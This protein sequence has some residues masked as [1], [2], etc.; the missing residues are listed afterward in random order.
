MEPEQ[1]SKGTEFENL[2]SVKVAPYR[3]SSSEYL[4]KNDFVLTRAGFLKLFYLPLS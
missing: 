1:V 3:I 2:E 4:R